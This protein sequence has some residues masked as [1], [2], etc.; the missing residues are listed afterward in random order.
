MGRGRWRSWRTGTGRW[1]GSRSTTPDRPCPSPSVGTDVQS[2]T[3]AIQDR[4]SGDEHLPVP[5]WRQAEDFV[6][7]W[8]RDQGF[9]RVSCT[10]KGPDKGLDVVSGQVA[11]QVKLHQ[12]KTSCP[13]VQRLVAA[14]GGPGR[15][16]R[17]KCFFSYAG[18]TRPALD[19][20][21]RW[22]VALFQ[23]NLEGTVLPINE[24]AAQALRSK[25]HGRAEVQ[26]QMQAEF[27]PVLE[28]EERPLRDSELVAAVL[29]LVAAVLAVAAAVHHFA[30]QG[31]ALVT[32]ALL[33]LPLGVMGVLDLRT[34]LRSRWRH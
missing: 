14:A 16:S 19:E 22:G 24:A 28:D 34:G 12:A 20:A 29:L 23:Y 4:P 5:R 25:G 8:L 26:Q 27:L 6:A 18:Y 13:E 30:G 2:V 17:L 15:R 10:G 31:P 32:L 3:I 1:G 33:M 11:A 7:D 21:E 9:G